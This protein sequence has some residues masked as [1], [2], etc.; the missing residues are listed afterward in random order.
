MNVQ[1]FEKRF[2]NFENLVFKADF[3]NTINDVSECI[4]NMNHDISIL[5]FTD[6]NDV[7]G[8]SG[9]VIDYLT[10][11]QLGF[12]NIKIFGSNDRSTIPNDAN[13]FDLIITNDVGV[14]IDWNINTTSTIVVTDH[15]VKTIEH[16]SQ[17]NIYE[18]VMSN[19]CGAYISYMLMS[20]LLSMY[21][22]DVPFEEEDQTKKIKEV[23]YEFAI[24][25][26]IA[27][28]MPINSL[29]HDNIQMLYYKIQNSEIEADA[30]KIML[31]EILSSRFNTFD[32]ETL[33]FYVIPKLNAPMKL[34][35]SSTK[36]GEYFD[37]NSNSN[38]WQLV[39]KFMI[40]PDINTYN[41]INQINENRKFEVTS[42]Y[43]SIINELPKTKIDNV[44]NL[45]I[46]NGI[47]F[48]ARYTRHMIEIN[49]P[50]TSHIT[51]LI[52]SKLTEYYGIPVVVN[53]N[54]FSSIRG[55]DSLEILKLNSENLSA[56]GGHLQAAG[57]K[58]KPNQILNLDAYQPKQKLQDKS[59]VVNWEPEF[60]F[61]IIK[62]WIFKNMPFTQKPLFKK[63]IIID[64]IRIFK[65]TH[66]KIF[67]TDGYEYMY[68]FKV[69]KLSHGDKMTITFKIGGSNIIIDQ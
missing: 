53:G 13:E 69:L 55:D 47:G 60:K 4:Y 67:D 45:T 2:M 36:T 11:K 30:L 62:D 7:D 24:L 39:M 64:K 50:I 27:D 57:F 66:T 58:L 44:N 38:D 26:T 40:N 23:I 19:I 14:N 3:L 65:N 5:I 32:D 12:H 56:F 28:C 42:I 63:E 1:D 10:L 61:E 31:D 17:L 33:S 29:N 21:D 9:A 18:I 46:F 15:H 20:E 41:I 22:F 35:N 34:N 6:D 37:I 59:N 51:G 48:K 8:I 25:A 54:A 52:A 16:E 49:I 68:F 43:Q